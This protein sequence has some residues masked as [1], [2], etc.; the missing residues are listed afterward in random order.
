MAAQIDREV[1]AK[2]FIAEPKRAVGVVFDE[3]R[4]DRS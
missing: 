4:S 2:T 3:I 1:G